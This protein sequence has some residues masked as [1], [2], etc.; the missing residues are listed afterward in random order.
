MCKIISTGKFARLG[1]P[2]CTVLCFLISAPAGIKGR[3]CIGS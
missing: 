2:G 3:V 1:V